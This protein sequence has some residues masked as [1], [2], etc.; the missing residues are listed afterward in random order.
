MRALSACVLALVVTTAV[1]ADEPRSLPKLKVSDN[2]RFLVTAEGKPFFYLADT[3]WELFH[4]LDREQ[5]GKYLKTRAAQGYN[6]VQAVA[7]AEFD[8]LNEPNVYGHKPLIDNSPAKPNEKYFEHVDWV[9]NRAAEHGI[10]TALLPTWGDKWNKKWGQGP[11]VF[12][13]ENAEAYGAWLGKRYKDRPIIWVLGGD[14]PVETDAHKRITRA[15]AKGLRAGDGGAH[16]ITF[17]PTGG[18]GSSTPFHNDDWLDFN[19]RQN[20]HQAEFTGRY[21]KTL[22]DYNLRPAKPVL[23]GEPIY[24]GHPVSFKAKE[25]GHSTAADV[26]RPFYWDVFSGACGH[27]YG[28]HSVWQFY[29]KGRKPVNSPLVTWEEAIE[30]PGGKQMQHGRRLIE[31]RPYLTR[32]PDD[33]VI[34]ADE[35]GTSVPGAGTRRF[36][37]TRDEKGTFAMVYVPIGRPF[38]VAM[39]KVTGPKVKAWWFNPRD[40][41]A[42]AVGTFPNTGTRTFT[43]PADGELLDWVLVLDDESKNFP[44]PGATPR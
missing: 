31:S 11:E 25:F 37:A 29:A 8:G 44:E 4:R 12:T 35:V 36:A 9:V 27:T 28:H 5:A 7:L 42:T 24:E 40:G 38:T 10:Y 3:A 41:K 22:A 20:G 26:R 18:S 33:S 32:V 6:V 30:Q 2:K 43:P 16:L 14:R 21:D 17:H 34:V 1:H 23:D 15:M 39:G 13:P 19:M